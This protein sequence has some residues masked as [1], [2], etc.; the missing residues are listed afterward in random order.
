MFLEQANKQLVCFFAEFFFVV[1]ICNGAQKLGV[2]GHLIKVFWVACGFA[3]TGKCPKPDCV[4]A[5]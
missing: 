4:G 2:A 1:D 3:F 5:C